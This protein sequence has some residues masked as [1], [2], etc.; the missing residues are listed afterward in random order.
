MAKLIIER[1]YSTYK[2]VHNV[3]SDHDFVRI[4]NDNPKSTGRT[5]KHLGTE[6]LAY[7][8]HIGSV[9]DNHG[10]G[11]DHEEVNDIVIQDPDQEIPVHVSSH[12]T[13]LKRFLVKYGYN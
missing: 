10:T 5:Y 9:K 3:L 6:H 2:Q 12:H 13:S 4:P 11:L 1:K 7:V 8:N